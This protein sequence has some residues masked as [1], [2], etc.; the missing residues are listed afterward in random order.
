VNGL[1]CSSE[2]A[3]MIRF[4]ANITKKIG[5]ISIPSHGRFFHKYYGLGIT[6]DVA[7]PTYVGIA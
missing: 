1:G 6:D 5:L 4:Y 3:G 2:E 7:A